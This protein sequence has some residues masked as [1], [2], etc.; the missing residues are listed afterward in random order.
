MACL[1]DNGGMSYLQRPF[2]HEA[3]L[4]A[5]L[6]RDLF[7]L[8]WKR[9]RVYWGILKG[10]T[11]CSTW[12]VSFSAVHILDVP[13]TACLR[14]KPS[15]AAWIPNLG[16]QVISYWPFPYSL[17]NVSTLMPIWSN[18]LS[19]WYRNL[20]CRGKKLDVIWEKMRASKH[21]CAF[22]CVRESVCACV[23]VCVNSIPFVPMHLHH[24][25]G[26]SSAC[27]GGCHPSL[28]LCL[29]QRNQ[30]RVQNHS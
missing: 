30:V 22:V 16:L 26:C 10:L 21:W 4:V 13:L 2:W 17:W 27:T 20:A 9:V 11:K 12:I 15:S 6:F 25:Q 5:I 14:M 23:C 24:W 7:Q 1:P 8:K 3:T 18:A 19:K 28:F 29:S